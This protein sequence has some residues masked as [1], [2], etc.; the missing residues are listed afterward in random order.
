MGSECRVRGSDTLGPIDVR[1][2][3]AHPESRHASLPAMLRYRHAFHAGNYA[4]VLKHLVVCR[5]LEHLT[6]KPAPLRYIDTH[7]GAG[8]YRLDSAEALRNGEFRRGI[9][10]LWD[11][12]DLPDGLAA[13]RDLVAEFNGG[14]VLRRY[15]GSPWFAQRLLRAQDRLDLCERHPRDF[16]TL[17]RRFRNDRRAGCHNEDGFTRSLVLVPPQ[18]GRA[19]VLIDPSYELKQD[20]T[21]VVAHVRALHRRFATGVYLVWYP[22]V[23]ACRVKRLEKAFISSGMRRLHLYEVCLHARHTGRGMSGAGLIVVNPPSML[24]EE[25]RAGLDVFAPLVSKTGKPLY[26]IVE[27]AGE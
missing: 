20:Y 26:R 22:L 12:T 6:Q 4:D 24:R 14:G 10:L 18:E 9:G 8:A 2:Q 13:Y 19:L 25:V 1:L 15:P 3:A 21:R 17:Q 7:A 27:L 16:P 11:R 5:V 23:E